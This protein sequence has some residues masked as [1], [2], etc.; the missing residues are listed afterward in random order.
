MKGSFIPLSSADLPL[1]EQFSADIMCFYKTQRIG[2]HRVPQLEL[3]SVLRRSTTK[4]EIQFSS[5]TDVIYQGQNATLQQFLEEKL[6][7][8]S[9]EL[10]LNTRMMPLPAAVTIFYEPTSDL[11]IPSSIEHLRIARTMELTFLNEFNLSYLPYLRSVF[12]GEGSFVNVTHFQITENMSLVNVFIEDNCFTEGKGNLIIQ[13]C[14]SLAVL[15]I[16]QG[17][18][19]RYTDFILIGR[20]N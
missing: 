9:K 2:I 12:I 18:F 10:H 1:L 16:G 11:T 6:D 3:F 14:P 5:L 19:I 4:Q 8:N 20:H 7:Y 13:A 15:S 17:C